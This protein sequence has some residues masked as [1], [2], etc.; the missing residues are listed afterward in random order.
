MT[1]ISAAHAVRLRIPAGWDGLTTGHAAG[2][3]QGNL[4][5]LPAEHAAAFED[6]CHANPRACPLL[7]RG[8]RGQAL[9]DTLGHDLDIR[10]DVGRYL[11]LEGGREVASRTGLGALWQNDFVAFVL[12]CWFSNEAALARAG[13]R[14]RHVEQGIQGGLFRTR[15][16]TQRC[17]PFGGPLLVSMRPFAA[18]DVAR[19]AAITAAAP[20]A[21][22]AP[23]HSGDPAGLGIGDLAFPDFGEALPPEAGEVPLYWA[24]GLTASAALAAAQLPLAI[25]H[26]PGCMVVTD[27]PA[28][29]RLRSARA[30][31]PRLFQ[32]NRNSSG[33][34]PG[35][36]G[37]AGSSTD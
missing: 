8:A 4:V 7:G 12:G 20:L 36:P 24:C 14:M 33:E 21:H 15:I 2:F 9:L 28:Q 13:I 5:I 31:W 26:A 32:V 11:I 19:V 25:T 17:G 27:L 3:L 16:A 22:G 1:A 6:F 10:T 30:A 34:S 35:S 18:A 23:L 37:C 29:D